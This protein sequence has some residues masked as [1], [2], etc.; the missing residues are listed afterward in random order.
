MNISIITITEEFLVSR[1]DHT[2]LPV[3]LTPSPLV[4]I[5]PLEISGLLVLLHIIIIN[6]L[7][8]ILIL[9]LNMCITPNLSHRLNI[10]L[11]LTPSLLGL[12]Y[13]LQIFRLRCV[14]LL[15]L[16]HDPRLFLNRAF[17]LHTLLP[18]FHP[19]IAFH[20]LSLLLLVRSPIIRLLRLNPFPH[21]PPRH[22]EASH[23][24]E[25]LLITFNN[26]RNRI[27]IPILTLIPLHA[28]TLLHLR[29]PLKNR[30]LRLIP[31][32]LSSLQLHR[33]KSE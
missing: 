22:L 12:L 9:I 33:S 26:I 15:H 21:V 30:P 27:M 25:F 28:L 14:N 23:P 17:V 2:L 3:T 24:L 4:R 5:P 29:Y 31:R 13:L 20:R 11:N 32:I 16:R 8:N 18:P 1:I 7:L 19:D 6:P 10:L